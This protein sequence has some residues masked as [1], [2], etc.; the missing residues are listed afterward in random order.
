MNRLKKELNKR[1][2][3]YKPDEIQIVMQGI[4]HDNEQTLI[5]F[6]QNVI[7]CLFTS[8]V[9]DSSFYFYSPK[10][11][12]LIAVQNVEL[13]IIP[14]FVDNGNKWNVFTSENIF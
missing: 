11:L 7:V 5:C 14:C 6:N 12:E 1:G 2:I 13:E 9:I 3:T 10:T 4:E 8:A